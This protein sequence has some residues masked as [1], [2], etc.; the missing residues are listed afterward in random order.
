VGGYF[1][2]KAAQRDADKKMAGASKYKDGVARAYGAQQDELIRSLAAGD[3]NQSDANARIARGDLGASLRGAAATN[4]ALGVRGAMM[5]GQESVLAGNV[6]QASGNEMVT[7]LGG[8]SSVVGQASADLA[9]RNSLRLQALK[10]YEEAKA[11]RKTGLR[12]AAEGA[13][14]G[15]MAGA[16]A[17]I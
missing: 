13:G 17:P 2:N 9:A 1:G 12:A 16:A 7:N 11:A 15:A 4:G 3:T 8:A 14:N 6:G 10:M 5:S